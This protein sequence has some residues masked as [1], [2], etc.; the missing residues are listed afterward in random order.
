MA[1]TSGRIERIESSEELRRAARRR[2]KQ[3][4]LLT[5]NAWHRVRQL[6]DPSGAAIVVWAQS[7]MILTNGDLLNLM[8]VS[9]SVSTALAK[10][11]AR[12]FSEFEA[13]IKGSELEEAM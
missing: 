5:R 1:S 4:V 12:A 8:R 11:E 10:V 13:T 9:R 3:R 7:R 2:A 6:Q